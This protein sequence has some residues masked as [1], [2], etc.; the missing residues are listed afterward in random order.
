MKLSKKQEKAID[1]AVDVLN[2]VLLY[3]PIRNKI[4]N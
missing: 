3:R 4:S 1:T 2:I